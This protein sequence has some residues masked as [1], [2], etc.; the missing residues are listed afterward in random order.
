MTQYTID[1]AASNVPN[2]IPHGTANTSS[3]QGSSFE[4][5]GGHGGLDEAL[6]RG[7]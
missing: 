6:V 2:F 4:G 7:R 1:G 3:G 5:I